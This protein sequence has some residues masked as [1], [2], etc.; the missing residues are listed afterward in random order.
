M[1]HRNAYQYRIATEWSEQNSSDSTAD[2][3]YADTEVY[4]R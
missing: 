2:N 4:T 1:L 3:K